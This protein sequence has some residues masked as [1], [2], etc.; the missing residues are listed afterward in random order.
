MFRGSASV[1][2]SSTL[3]INNQPAAS[4]LAFTQQ[5]TNAQAG[6]IISPAVQLAVEDSNGHI[7][8]NA[9]NAITL[10]LKGGT[11]LAGTL[12]ATPQNGIV[13]FNNLTVS[14]AGAGLNLLAASPG[15][16]AAQ[17]AGFTVDAP[18]GLPA[19]AAPVKLVFLQQPP[20]G[21]T[22]ATFTPA[23]RVAIEDAT[24]NVVSAAT[25][26]VT[27]ALTTG[28]A[29][30]GT[31][32]VAAQN[33]IATFSNLSVA[34]AGTGYA[35]LATSSSLTSATSNPFNISA[36]SS[37]LGL[38]VKL[39]FVQEPV[40]GVIQTALSPAVQ[41]AIEDGSGQIVSTAANAVTIG[42]TNGMGLGGTLTVAPVNGVATFS[43]LTE[44]TTGSGYM[45]TATSVGL[46]AATSTT[47][48]I[49]A[50]VVAPQATQLA[51]LQQ[52]A[53]TT[54]LAVMAPP[55]Q[56]GVEDANG[57]L[58]TTA[59]STIT[60]A[61]KGGAGLSGTL[62]VA[63][64]NGIAT[65]SNLSVSAAGAGYLLSA[66]SPG[67][68]A[69]TSTAFNITAP[70]AAPP[71]PTK[72]AFVQQPTSLVASTVMSP[73]VQVAI[74][75][76]SGKILT[77]AT[78]SVTVA[79]AS[80]TGLSGALTAAAVNGIATFN[81]L[82]VNNIGT[83]DSL[84]AG[85]SGLTGVTSTAFNVTA[86]PTAPVK[87]AFVQQPTNALTQA[88]ITPA[89]Q[90]A[91]EDAGGNVMASATNQVTLTL[92]SGSGLS[93]TLTVA[94]VN[95]V[96]SFT[97]LMVNNPGSGLSLSANSAGLQA[98]TSNTF[99]ISAPPVIS[100]GTTILPSLPMN[101]TAAPG[102]TF[103]ITYHW[104]A[105]PVS[106]PYSVFVN[107]VD[108]S[109]TVQFEDNV[110]P[111]TAPSVWN[112]PVSY[113]HTVTVPAG[114]GVGT[115]TIVA[116][117]KSASS[118]LGIVGGAGVT[119]LGNGEY[120]IGSM[121]LEPTCSITAFGAVGD[122]VTDN[123]TAIQ[124]TFN[125]AAIHR[126]VALIPAGTFAYSGLLTATGIAVQGTGAASILAPLS[127][128]NEALSLA[129]SGGSISNLAMV[130]T[131]TQRLTTPWSGM[132]WV[133]NAQNYYVDNVLIH[134]SSSIGIM[135]YNSSNGYIFNNTVANT[136][137]DA[138]TQIEGSH[139]IT[140]SNNRII[141][142]GDDG[143][144]NNSYVGSPMVHDITV[145]GNTVLNNIGGRGLEVSGGANITF[146]GNYVDN[147][148]GYTDVY[149]ASES[150]WR[151]LGVS[152]VT[153]SAN[154]LVAGGPNQGSALI[155]NSQ[156][157]TYNISG[158]TMTGN[159]FVNPL[160]V[161]VQLTGT[162]SETGIT[163]QNNTDYSNGVFG[164]LGNATGTLS[165]NQVIAPSAFT[166]SLA[167][168]GGGC[169]FS[170]C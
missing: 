89:V 105:L 21:L 103:L 52:P 50:A 18:P 111:P 59:G 168:A 53:N 166:T 23:I 30:G 71:V 54:A 136:L 65:F 84:S 48:S 78:N 148:D 5:P 149:I 169:T 40:N 90:V 81:G 17:S 116:G 62:S 138:I 8:A 165:G 63:A 135:S 67:L 129:G 19:A 34:V 150:E 87:L 76:A 14:S 118:N 154:T 80:G 139:D 46:S 164:G 57:N 91:V 44:S 167:P 2:A 79:L 120:Q 42:L 96:A 39:V 7:I 58:V 141:N 152:N 69:A 125:Y 85:S 117:L 146:T 128:S 24:G 60:L 11:G 163:I 132:I 95:G 16:A 92:V 32:T 74:E 9:L 47:F 147:P 28:A 157:S 55:V 12:T 86:P 140:V 126:C 156:G 162:G 144:S 130:S 115:Y 37:P 35:L 143:I 153:V 82:T 127:L 33:G 41:V 10:T 29:L 66:G 51:F 3:T 36:Q 83:G 13:T 38:P 124:S 31:V 61:L 73:P 106:G 131:A 6:S 45:L 93:G 159:Q 107:F 64:M 56:V 133:N 121:A 97:T 108:S 122:G 101:L 112:G 1:V 158:V 68:T 104:Q 99:T 20:S 145:Q 43:N 113:T 137:A 75:D 102:G 70:I 98:A 100:N 134:D 72:L 109:G 77:T 94:A 170:G 26:P 15:L 119:A 49:T 123:L 151:T 27:L 4:R 161:A 25:N 110:Q 142:C 114:A 160:L 88:P 155:Y 22:G